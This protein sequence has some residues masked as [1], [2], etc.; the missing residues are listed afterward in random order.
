M[1]KIEPT[2]LM[3]STSKYLI[4]LTFSFMNDYSRL[5]PKTFKPTYNDVLH[6]RKKTKNF[7]KYRAIGDIKVTITDCGGE[8]LERIKWPNSKTSITHSSV[9]SK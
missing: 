3:D 2:Y 7:T 6:M 4:L 5:N 1:Q 8:K 9:F